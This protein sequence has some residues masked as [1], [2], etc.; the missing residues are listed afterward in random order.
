[1]LLLEAG[2]EV[3]NEFVDIPIFADKVRGS[4]I[5]WQ[6]KTTTQ[7]HACKSHEDGVS[8]QGPVSLKYLRL[9]SPCS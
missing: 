4:E 2:D 1:M 7:K 8:K 6:Y 5:D 3:K 9:R